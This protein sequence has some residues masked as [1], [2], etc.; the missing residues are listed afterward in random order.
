MLGGGGGP[1]ACYREIT[2]NWLNPLSLGLS[3]YLRSLDGVLWGDF[4]LLSVFLHFVSFLALLPWWKRQDQKHR[5]APC[6][7]RP[8]AGGRLCLRVPEGPPWGSA[9]PWPH[10]RDQEV[11]LCSDCAVVAFLPPASVGG[12]SLP[13]QSHGDSTR[14]VRET[15]PNVYLG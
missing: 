3:A 8:R 6:L 13:P 1:F 5:L 14:W 12:G 4:Y 9:R 15:T 10:P 11:E 7:C 2:S